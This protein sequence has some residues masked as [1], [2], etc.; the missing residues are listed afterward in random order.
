MSPSA[1]FHSLRAPPSPAS[2]IILSTPLGS[3]N[4]KAPA[5]PPVSPAAHYSA[6][7]WSPAEEVTVM[8]AGPDRIGL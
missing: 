1:H 2:P 8:M 7:Q 4:V 6:W 3:G 5:F